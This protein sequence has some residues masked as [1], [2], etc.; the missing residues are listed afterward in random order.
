MAVGHIR[1]AKV[2]DRTCR[3]GFGLARGYPQVLLFICV[4][5][6]L[7]CFLLCWVVKRESMPMPMIL[8]QVMWKVWT[9]AVL[10]PLVE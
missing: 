8:F 9:F 3:S 4:N 6:S 10:C 7:C 1:I 2:L 5:L